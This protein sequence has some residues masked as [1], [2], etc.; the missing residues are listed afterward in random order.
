MLMHS[1]ELS[2]GVAYRQLGGRPYHEWVRW[3]KV[4]AI[5]EYFIFGPCH[6]VGEFH[7]CCARMILQLISKNTAGED[8]VTLKQT[9]L[10]KS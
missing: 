6:L 3:G 4:N 1:T 10:A 8:S 7:L 9:L 2:F 5:Y